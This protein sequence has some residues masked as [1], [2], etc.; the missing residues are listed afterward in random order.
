MTG[1]ESD[2]SPWVLVRILKT[3]LQDTDT[4]PNFRNK[5]HNQN[6]IPVNNEIV[7]NVKLNKVGLFIFL[8][9]IQYFGN[10]KI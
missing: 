3:G 6:L 8:E 9:H 5:Y 7:F 1:S 4:K 2:S 10:D